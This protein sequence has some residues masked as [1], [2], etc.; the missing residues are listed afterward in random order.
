M[1][2][3]FVVLGVIGRPQGIK[4]HV[5]VKAFTESPENLTSYGPLI[6]DHG[7]RWVVEWKSEGIAAL[8]HADS[9]VWVSDRTMAEKLVN[10]TLS[11]ARSQLPDLEEDEYYYSDLIGLD[12]VLTLSDGMEERGVVKNIHD[13][14]AGASLEVLLSSNHGSYLIPFLKAYVPRVD[15]QARILYALLPEE[16]IGE[17]KGVSQQAGAKK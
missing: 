17:E 1:T 15:M 13:Y 6:D 2:D 16:I 3:K 5:R 11:I 8:R 12:V 14:G 4:G 7:E 9:S 10:R